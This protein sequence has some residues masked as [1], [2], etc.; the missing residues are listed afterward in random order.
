MGR[1]RIPGLCSGL[2]PSQ[3]HKDCG[4]QVEQTEQLGKGPRL[5]TDTSEQNTAFRCSQR[6]LGIASKGS[7]RVWSQSPA[8]R[9][10][11][12]DA[13]G[14]GR[15]MRCRATVL[16]LQAVGVGVGVPRA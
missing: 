1:D 14:R 12:R 3:G 5:P 6:L 8:P 4:S 10:Q 9:S 16:G 2:G 7:H 15:G 13:E 11:A